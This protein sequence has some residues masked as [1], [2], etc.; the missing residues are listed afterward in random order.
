MGGLD[1]STVRVPEGALDRGGSSIDEIAD[2]MDCLLSE[3][4]RGMGPN[5]AEESLSDIGD[6]VLIGKI[7]EVGPAD[8][9]GEMNWNCCPAPTLY[10]PKPTGEGGAGAGAGGIHSSV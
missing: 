10:N 3:R 2:S 7:V 9:G 5:V 4:G 6:G 8:G 1:L